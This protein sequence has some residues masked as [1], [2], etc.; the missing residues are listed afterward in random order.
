M[1]SRQTLM[2]RGFLLPCLPFTLLNV[3]ESMWF[4]SEGDSL[5]HE[6]LGPT[7]IGQTFAL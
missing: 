1:L 4:R 5:S 7:C 3:A 2:C 6:L